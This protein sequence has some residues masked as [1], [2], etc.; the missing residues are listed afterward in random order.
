M[1]HFFQQTAS[2]LAGL[3]LLVSSTVASL[4]EKFH[5][6]TSKFSYKPPVTSPAKKK[7]AQSQKSFPAVLAATIDRTKTGVTF[8][9]PA[10]FKDL[11]TLDSSLEVNGPSTFNDKVTLT[12]QDLD[13][14]TGELTASNVLYGLTAGN[15][16]LISEGQTPEIKLDLNVVSSISGRTGDVDLEEGSGISIDGL[17]I[18]NSDK[19]SAQNIFKTFSVSGQSDI[20]ANSNTSKLTFVAGEGTVL[21]TDATAKTLTITSNFNNS[22]W[23]DEGA[24]IRLSGI[25]DSVGIGT[26][27]PANKLSVVGNTD[28]SGNLGIGTTTPAYKLDV[29]GNANL[30]SGSTYKINGADVLSASGLGVGVTA[31]SLTSLGTL[32]NVTV[33]GTSALNGGITF[34]NATDTISAFT[35][36]G[37][38]NLANNLITNVGN[39]GTDFTASGGLTLAGLLTASSGISLDAETVTDFS[40]NGIVVTSNSLFVNLTTSSNTGATSS[41]SGLEVG[42]AG[43]TLLKG[44]S[45]GELLKYTDAGGWA[46]STDIDTTSGSASGFTDFGSIVALITSADNLGVGTSSPTNKLSVVGTADISGNLGV[47]TTTP[48]Y[49]LDVAGNAN[50]ASGFTYKVNGNDVLSGTTLG[51]G[52]TSSSLTQLGALG[53]LTVTGAIV[54]N[55]GLTLAAGQTLNVNSDAITDL[56]GNGIVLSGGTLTVGLTS[57]GTTGSS[58][59]NSGLEVGSAGLTLLKGCSDNELLKYTD[60]SGWACAI[61]IDTTGANLAGF[62]DF[63]SIVALTTTADNLG[64]GTSSPTNKLSVVGTADISGN[65]GIGTTAP[66]YK[67]DVA[68]NVNLSTGSTLKINGTDV[69]SASGLGVGV[70]AS[71]LTSLGTLGN[72]TVTGVSA[73]NGGITFDS[74]TD[75]ISAFTAGGTI[76]MAT[77]IITDIGNSGTDFTGA[78]GLNLAGLL[79]ALSGVSINSETVTDFSGSGISVSG[80]ALTV[81]LTSSGTT[82]STSSNSGL[83][84]GSGGLTLLKGCTDGELLKYTDAGGWACATDTDTNTNTSGFTDFGSIVALTTT[85]D[86]LGVGTSSPTNKLSVVGNTDISGNLGV[87]TTTPAYKLDVAGSTNLS[88][89]STYKINGTDVLSASGLGVGVTASSLTS[90]GPLGNLTVTGAIVGNGG[91]TLATG[92]TFTMNGDAFTDL[93]GSGIIISGNA[94]TIGL[95]TS[96]TTGS[97][98]SNSGLEVGSA[99]LT[100]LKGCT[101][102]ELLKYTD[103]GGWACSAD[104]D[105]DTNSAG[106]TDFGSIVALTTTADSVGIGTSSPANKLSV[107]GTAD[108]SGNLGIGTTTPAYKLDVAGSANLSTGS[109]YKINGTD[110]LSGSTLGS[111]I[112]ASSLTSV[113]TLTNL[114]VGNS[115]AFGGGILV[116]GETLTDFTGNGVTLS[117]GALTVNLTSSGT[118][119]ST[120]S[121]SGLEVGS[122]GLTLLKGCTDGELLK[123]TDAGGWACATDSNSGNVSGFTD[124]GSIV[125]LTTTADNLGVGTSSPTNKLSVVGTADISGNLGI[126][127]TTPAYKLDVAGN[128]N[129]SSGSTY[130]INGTDVLSASGLGVGV[131]ASSL[132]SLGTL[133]N[134]TVTGA[135]VGNGGLT[136]AAGQTL[137]F[138]SDAITDL[139]GNGIVLSGGTL[140]VGL[141]SSGTTG[142][143]SSNSGLEVGSGGLTLLKGCIDG[144]LLKYT[145]AGGWA[146]ATDTDTNT[147]NISGFTDFGSIVALTTTADNLGVGTS[148]PT[149]KL[150]VVGTADISGNLGIGTTT[151]AFK[152]DVAGSANLSSG[153]TYKINGTD[154][155]SGNTLGSGITASS[156]TS[157]GTLTNLGVG[158]SGSF[159]GGLL[160][161][162]QTLTNFTGNG[163]TLSSGALTVN[164]TTSGTTGS[165]SSNSGLEV[166][167]G[168]LTLLKGCTDGELLKY[169]DAS[170]WACAADTDTDTNTSGFTDFGSIVALTTT[171]DNLGVGTSSPTNK[172]SVVG[173]ADISGNLG[174]GTTTPAY[175]LD[176]V[177]SAN[178]SAGSTYK[179]N[180]T[181]VLSASGLGVGVTASSLT[182]LGTLGNVTVTGTSALNG[183]ITFDSS[184]DTISAFTAGGTIDLATNLITNIGNAGTDFVAGGGL[185]LAGAFTANS[186]SALNGATTLGDA[187]A[188]T[189]TSNAGVWS[190]TN[191]TT[192]D[193]ADSS[194]Q[195]LNFESGLFNLDTLNGR[196]GIGT[197]TPTQKLDVVGNVNVSSGST[198]KIAGTDVLSG[199]TLG[200]GIT[201]SSL[202]SVGTLTNLGVGNSGSFGG[203]ILVGGETLTD[204]TGNGVTLSSGALTVNLTTS[205]TTGSTSSNSGLEVGSGGL[206]LLKG[207][208][209]GELLKYTDASGW[210]CA[211]DTDTNTGNI[212]GFTDFGSI[213]A[214]TTTTDNLGVG[215]SSPTNKLSVVGTADISG[216]LGVGTTTPAYK[217]DV[218]GNTNLSSG[219][220]YKINGTDVLSGNTLGSGITASSLTSVGTLTNLGVGNSG[221]FGGGLLVGGQT[222]TN[223]T[224]NG[225]TL[226]SGAL[227]VNL[228]TS[229]TT[230]STSSNSG[231]EVGS[232]G[233][234]LLKGCSDGEILKYTDAGGWACAADVDNDTNSSGFTDFGSIVALTTTADN[235]GVGTSSPTNK[236]S[237]VGTADISGN[238]GVGTT[239]PAYKLEIIGTGR[240]SGLLTA[241]A[242]VSINSETVTDFSGSGIAV[243][244]NALTVNLATSGTT[245]STSSSSGLEVGAG[246][247]TLLKGCNDGEILKYT[248]AGGWA[249]VADVD[250]DTN[251]SGFTDYGSI[252]ALTTTADSVG[253]GTSSPANKLSVVGSADVS[254]S[255]GIGTTAP[256]YNLEVIGTGR[257]SGL[258]TASSGVSINGETVTDLSGSGIVLTGNALTVNLTNSGTTGSTSSNSGLE[259][260]SGG[261]TLLKGCSDGEILKYT[262]AGGWACAADVDNDTN[263]SGFTDFGSIVAMT[264]SADNLGVGTSS[265]TNKLSVVGTA[266]ISGNLGVGTTIPAYKLDVVGSAN[267]SS[268]STYKINGT[269]V[270]S[271]SGLGVGVTASSLTSLGTLGNVTVAGVS[272]LNGGITFDNSTDTISAFTAGGTIDLAT[273]LITNIGNAG[274]DFVAGGGLTL[275]GAFTANSTSALN[276]AV[277]LGDASS[278]TVTSNAGVWSFTNATT[279]DL[280]DNARGAL[281]FEGGLLALDTLNSRI[282]IGTTTPTQKLDVVGNVNVS[283]GSTY[284]INGTDVLSGNTLGAGITASSLTSVGTLTNLGVGNSGSFGGGLLVGGQTLTNFTGNGVTLSS[285]AL[286]VNLT[287]S[288]TTGSTSSNSG[289]EVGSGGLTLLKGCTDGELLKYTDA[290]G[291]ACAADTDTDTNTSGF[292]DFGSIVALTTTADNLGVGTSSP[293]N[294]LSVV[295]NADISGNLGVGTTTPAYKLDVAGN[296]NLS[297][298]STY[299][300]NGTDVISASGLGVGVTASSLTSLGTLGNL[301][302]AGTSALNG[303]ITFDNSTDTIS[304]FTAGGTIDL[305]TNLITNIGNAGTDFSAGGGLTLAGAF[306]A[307]STTALNGATTLGDAAADTVTSNA[308]VWSF[309]NATTVDLADSSRGALNFEGGLL[310]LDT[311]NSRIGIGTTTPTQK[312]DVA[313]NVN[314]SSGSTYKINGT[315]VLSASGLGVGVTASSLTSLGTLGNVTVTGTSALNGGITFDSATDTISAFTAGGTI[316]LATNLI[317]NIG[318]SGTDFIAG[319]GLTLAGAFTANST[320]ALNGA[321]TLGDASSDMVTSNAG[322]WSFT[323]ATTVDLAD[324]ARGALNFEGGLLALDTLNSRIG[325]GTTTP[326]QKLDV[327]GNVNVSSGSTYKIAGTDVLSGN[328]L[329][330][331]ITASS[332]TSV[333]TLTNLGVGNSGS[334]GGGLLVGGQTLTNFTG[335]GVTLSSGAL[336]VNLTTSGTTGSTSSNSGLEVGSGGLTLLKGC[337]DGELLKYTDASGWAC[338]TDTDTNTGNISGFTDF[339]SIVALTTTADNLGVGTSSPTNKLSVVG[340]ADISGNLGV[341]TTTPAY[342]LDVAGSANLSTGSTYKINGTDVLSASGLGVGVTASSLTSLGTLGNVTVTGTSALNGGITFDSSTDTISAFTA[343]GTI[344]L[345]TNLI[346]NIG[347]AGT[348]FVA[349][350]GLTLA[351]AFTANSTSALNGATTLGDAAADTVTSNAGVWVFSNATTVDLAD[352]SR[353]A[354][355][356]EGG[357]LVLDTLNSRIG[358]GTTTPTQKLDV[359]GNVN[360]SSGSTYKINGTDV[361][362]GNTLGSGVTASSLTSVGTLTNL[363]VGNSGAFGGGLLVGGQTL[364]N[365]TGNGVTLSS[366]ALT[367]NLTASGTTGST[368]SNS[369]LEVGSGGLTL[370][371]G[372]SDNELLKYTDA[373]GWACAVDIDTTGANVSGF[374]DFGSIVALT[375]TADNLG[376]GT[377]SPTNKLSVVGNADISGNLGI[378]TTTPAYKLDVAGNTNLSSGSTYKINGTDVISASGLGVGVTASSLTSLGTLGNVTVTGTS[379]LNGGITFDSATDIISAFTAGGTINMATN[380]ITDIGD[381]GT[382]FIAGGGLTLAGAFTA[383]STAVLNGAVTLGDVAADTVTA[384]AGV[385]SFANATTV[386]LADSARG[387]LNFEGGLLALDT[388]NSRIGIGTTTPTTTLDVVGTG[389]FS[390]LLTASSGLSINSETVTDFSGS[391]IVVTGNA[392]TV[393]LTS[394]GTTGS[395]SSN[396]G[397]EVGSAGLTLLKGCADGEILEYTDA[398]GWACA[399]DSDTGN[400]SGFTDFGS[401]VALTTTADN[402]GV[403]TSSPTNKLSVVGTA[404]ISGNLGV[405]TTTPAYKLDVAG[406]TNLSSGSTYKINGTDVLSASGLGVGVTASSLT[407]LGTLGNVTVAGVSALNG[408]ITFDNSTDTI[409]AFTLGG[410]QDA[411]TNLIVNIGDNGTDFIAGGGLTLAGAFT[412]NSTSA[413]NGGVTLGDASDD[414]VTSNAGIWSYAN[415]TTIDLV[416]SARNALNI[417]GGLLSL[418]TLNSRVGIGSSSSLAGLDVQTTAWLRGAVAGTSGLYVNGSGNVG[419]GI[420]MPQNK[421]DVSGSVA[422]GSLPTNQLPQANSAYFSGNVGIGTTNPQ[423]N[424]NVA[425]NSLST[426]TGLLVS[427]TSTSFSSGKLASIDWS[428]SSATT[429]T[430]DVLSVNVGV[431]GVV[432]NIFNVMDG[433]SSVFSVSQ[434][435][436]TAGLP[437]NFTAP[438]DVGIAYDLLFSNQTASNIKSY[439]PLTIE[440]GESFES[441]YL[442][443]KTYNS[444]QIVFDAPGGILLAQAQPWTLATSAQALNIQNGLLNLDTTNSRV[445]IGTSNPLAGFDVH[446]TAWLRGAASGASGLYVNGS[447]NVG[448][449]TSAPKNKLDVSGSVAFG[450]LPTNP[451]PQANSAYFSGNLGIGTTNPGYKLD[452][453]GTVN[454]SSGSTYKINGT[455]VLSASGLGVGVTASSLTSLGTL[456][457]VT[458]AGVSALNGG[459]TFDNSTDTISAFTLGGT[460]DAAT[461]LIVNIG[462]NGTDFIAGGGLTLAGAFTANSTSAL[463]GGVT[464]GDAS[465]DTVTSNAGIWSYANSTTIDLVNSAR[466]ALNI[467]GGLLS[468]DTLNSRVGIGSS[469]SLAGLDVQTTAWLRGAVA[470]TSGLY[471]NGSGNVGIGITMP[472][473]K[474]DVSGS[475]AFGSLPTNPLPQSNSA[476]FS[477]NVGIGTTNPGFGLEVNGTARVNGAV[478]FGDAS[479]D[480]VTSTAGAW[481]FSNASTFDLA[482]SQLN[483]LNFESGLLNIDTSGSTVGIGTTVP[484]AKLSVLQT[485]SANAFLVQDVAS[486]TTPFVIDASGRVGIGTTTP[487]DSISLEVVGDTR[488]GGNISRNAHGSNNL[489]DQ[490]SISPNGGFEGLTASGANLPDD[491]AD[492]DSGATVST[493]QVAQGDRSLRMSSLNDE[494]M[495]TCYPATGGNTLNFNMSSYLTSGDTTR[496]RMREYTT[497][498]NCT[499]NTSPTTTDTTAC[500]GVGASPVWAT[501]S[502]AQVLVAGTRWMR[503]GIYFHTKSSTHVYVDSVRV[504]QNA[505]TN[506]LDLAE[507]Y[508]AAKADGIKVGEIVSF[509]RANK[510][511]GADV[512]NVTRSSKAYDNL[513]FG[514]V[515]TKPGIVLD[516][517]G[518]S[519]KV[520]VALKGRVPVLVSTENGPIKIGD[521]IVASSKPGVGMKATKAGKI[522]GY[523]MTEFVNTDPSVID[524]V[525]VFVESS[526]FDPS[527]ALGSTGDVNGV[528]STYASLSPNNTDDVAKDLVKISSDFEKLTLSMNALDSKVEG[529]EGEVGKLSSENTSLTARLSS[530][531]DKLKQLEEGGAVLG[532]GSTN[533]QLSGESIASA[534]AALDDADSLI[535]GTESKLSEL[536]VTGLAKLNNLNVI[537]DAT[538]GMMQIVGIDPNDGSNIDTIAGPLRLQATALNDLD[539]MNGKVLVTT[540]GNI[541]TKGQI[542]AKKLNISTQDD[543]EDNSVGV[544]KLLKGTKKVIVKTTAITAKSHVFVTPKTLL[545]YPLVVTVLEPQTSFT[546]E[547]KSSEDKDVEFDWFIVN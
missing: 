407:S 292:T 265:P 26:S 378:G 387:A 454:I 206:T 293:T 529:V 34:D 496:L 156:L 518:A 24:I 488:L 272:A 435:V 197:T 441:N 211:T 194:R 278:D 348:D 177:G 11:V 113:G 273:N 174:V 487:S 449:G 519:E 323:N 146:C 448:I 258:L 106:F 514:I 18:T 523:A 456:G 468:L 28:I 525:I 339:G 264:T 134:L 30:S 202:T 362:S 138:N 392:L 111:G 469:S 88:S 200:A 381:A 322:V 269:D 467:E 162:G 372:C 145:D 342:K 451:L 485:G 332:L 239:T 353:G 309:T 295:G 32:G 72:V 341:G 65:L 38:I 443:L 274:T 436:I 70:T 300:I 512:N 149:N 432:G 240:L 135:I 17:E 284:K 163:V 147:G 71:S 170:G 445:G 403:G 119:G 386:N 41:N 343:G 54:G 186:T 108:I 352:S 466:N 36:G 515:S 354:L 168:G 105:T 179:I 499:A 27:S 349:G 471:V 115:G 361:L 406:N 288:G 287:T 301:T 45:D 298:G 252:V 281:N 513:A 544:A 350:G 401:I 1:N 408:G 311:L 543:A 21:T 320:S 10:F 238:L 121:N 277:T 161:G 426:G 210:A 102:G 181:D 63:G 150:S 207:C 226:S 458:V 52:V 169:T 267:L 137:N 492:V 50:L 528:A 335:N 351:G 385:W 58:S 43:L 193:L 522:L 217:L 14:G 246:G 192:V 152:L 53:N 87:G 415:S 369:G 78:G 270:I 227:T 23:V 481:T 479:S 503:T 231:L 537:G 315:D 215:T 107:V 7:T 433:G 302:V 57:S 248:D 285:G 308:G 260:G 510:Q 516:D 140:T 286:T 40:G 328:T 536:T 253:I 243:T 375:T 262:D 160:V 326:T 461:N 412:A 6:F 291:W 416:N 317:T 507:T 506:G 463:N 367:V 29:A 457:N 533:P 299:K 373:S 94:L 271:A 79:T 390:G 374:T 541:I 505:L 212:S 480:T 470:G 347:N 236:L 304:A 428:P 183:G 538:F 95:T 314:I 312:L 180:G 103:A 221:A 370:L 307:N 167:S 276:G 176:V 440:S 495:S 8:T 153:S 195:A 532:I 355:N 73:L 198:Y 464:L 19:G 310:A 66:A 92:Q 224:G 46:C 306:T 133:G 477:G 93:T 182:S 12:N 91:L 530:L 232:G 120:S 475:V 74:T 318:N 129:L 83:E 413:L 104:I 282:G 233:L 67:L 141:T 205:G 101:D 100:L 438:G 96:G 333:G 396:S 247:L 3:V 31:S 427:S 325:I 420:T 110:V 219:S 22:G 393:N 542:T 131:T 534:S 423:A 535:D 190:F 218:A 220:T 313:G 158:N 296:T 283:S 216:N 340:T 442:T 166:G 56:T 402:L 33:T 263:S 421:L 527:L 201:T 446:N 431:N 330:A 112:T 126:G 365:F 127:T 455:D 409:S 123:Y 360:V 16:I 268:G 25:S 222:L 526:W 447:G 68:G 509:G 128:T 482:N 255:F 417:E 368:S 44:C 266:D 410:T 502:A 81:N 279:V 86:N 472:Q 250:N 35:A 397:L 508:P 142:S 501:C 439:G 498:A 384:N 109:T 187:A 400:I 405:G 388:L 450:S 383:N 465:D 157:V 189:V 478:T 234:T 394:S 214:L 261:L 130:K 97:T 185:T 84:V 371:K 59:S 118:T 85:A 124:F 175:K 89:G 15:G 430:G 334:F 203:G 256:A 4:P 546:V 289:L 61:D 517:Q 364:T 230:G 259:V 484:T 165:T 55:G 77:N 474:L 204:F 280:A 377:S 42:T 297:S 148:S 9:I 476:Y 357:L 294:K 489:N 13:L 337:T 344:D 241:S 462:D 327:V 275:A 117:S 257:V 173:T 363:G 453:A 151:P 75:T 144:E 188:D 223:F 422:F 237:V 208:T 196:V 545:D 547:V 531:E 491:W 434:S 540:D 398:G 345:A 184:T 303:G 199:N 172:L 460:Q 229:G 336:T 389:K 51:V 411:A 404:D 209:D 159:G 90:V 391:G 493:T 249:C 132:T 290:G 380:I 143:T 213:V 242:G 62:T 414:T 319:G 376:V 5:D 504:T 452:V 437:V 539:I 99:G 136:L 419:I 399:V 418:D 64:V 305:A 245:G 500:T 395:T 521:P 511:V 60:A 316:D 37:T 122:A 483:A 47:G 356:F 324:N 331:G 49:K 473:N 329:G 254:G 379:A 429:A 251:N 358:I 116:G 125:A 244:G 497:L 76:N 191:A 524:Q 114:G 80:N 2:I 382:D 425:N 459:I 20:V 228:T 486:D 235:L 321:V 490:G 82:G 39:A 178:L 171:A 366:G 359:V 225:V 338:A 155:L 444:G 154:V 346:T 520:Q 98:S 424:L 48:G 494:V 164:L 69:L 139:T